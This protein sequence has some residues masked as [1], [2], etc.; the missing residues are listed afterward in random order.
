MGLF[1]LDRT[2]GFREQTPRAR[3]RFYILTAT[4]PP[5]SRQSVK[6]KS[7]ATRSSTNLCKLFLPVALTLHRPLT[8]PRNPSRLLHDSGPGNTRLHVE[9]FATLPQAAHFSIAGVFG[10]GKAIPVFHSTFEIDGRNCALRI[11]RRFIA[12]HK[13]KVEQKVEHRQEKS[14]K[15]ADLP[16]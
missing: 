14:E 7:R 12:L 4:I 15:Q 9:L 5:T 10:D 16:R 13:A 6:I 2:G 3:F 1:N 11:T 8:Y